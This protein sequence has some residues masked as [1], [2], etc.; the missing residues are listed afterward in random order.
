MATPTQTI[1]GIGKANTLERELRHEEKE[2]TQMAVGADEMQMIS[3]RA[4]KQAREMD[5]KGD[6]SIEQRLSGIEERVEENHRQNPPKEALTQREKEEPHQQTAE[7]KAP[8]RSVKKSSSEQVVD[9]AQEMAR[10]DYEAAVGEAN[11]AGVQQSMV[12]T[13]SAQAMQM[14]AA[15]LRAAV[16]NNVAQSS[17]FAA[18]SDSI[19]AA[20]SSLG[21]IAKEIKVD[22][23]RTYNGA[24]ATEDR[25]VAQ[26]LKDAPLAAKTE[27]TSSGRTA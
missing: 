12:D 6:F 4:Q 11:A 25:A 15:D 18:L 9:S 22:S 19:R 20:V 2:I 8:A 24:T 10:A 23:G 3:S 5:N 17:P 1:P 14:A 16:Q 7:V 27:S 26:A 21:D 13:R